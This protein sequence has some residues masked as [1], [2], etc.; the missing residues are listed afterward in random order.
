MKRRERGTKNGKRAKGSA[1]MR[2]VEVII[3]S[4]E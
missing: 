2:S 4:P 3:N 1:E